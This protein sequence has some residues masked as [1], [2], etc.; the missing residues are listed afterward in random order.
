MRE[1]A[2]PVCVEEQTTGKKRK[3]EEEKKQVE[4]QVR[5]MLS[6]AHQK[7]QELCSKH[8]LPPA[9]A[10]ALCSVVVKGIGQIGGDQ[11]FMKA[12]HHQ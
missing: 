7:A 11:D 5:L 2:Q 3:K 4:E 1:A 9:T 10:A 8:N 6:K 12:C